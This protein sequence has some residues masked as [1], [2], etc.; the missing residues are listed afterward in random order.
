MLINTNNSF[1][2]ILIITIFLLLYHMDTCRHKNVIKKKSKTNMWR[3]FYV[4][5]QF[6]T[7]KAVIFFDGGRVGV[8]QI[9]LQP[10]PN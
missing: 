8:R 6:A 9:K 5:L 4:M 3:T 7:V 10:N 1:L 2:I